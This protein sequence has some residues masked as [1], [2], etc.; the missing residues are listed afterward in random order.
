MRDPL[1]VHVEIVDCSMTNAWG[2][3]CMCR[4]SENMCN[5]AMAILTLISTR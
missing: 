5:N 4:A 3:E 2:I 1:I